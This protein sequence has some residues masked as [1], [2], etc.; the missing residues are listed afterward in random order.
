MRQ[1][2]STEIKK[3]IMTLRFKVFFIVGAILGFSFLVVNQT[4]SYIITRD[5]AEFEQQ[6]IQKN[7]LRVADAMQGRI[8]E[9]AVK[10]SDWAQ[11][12]DTYKYIGDR[13][14]A[15]I[16]SNLQNEALELLRINTV[17]LADLEGNILFGKQV[18]G[19]QEAIPP[20]VFLRHLTRDISEKHINTEEVHGEI[21]PLP[22]SAMIYVARPVT[23]SDGRAPSNGYIAF[24]YFFDQEIL[25]EISRITHLEIQSVFYDDQSMSGEFAGIWKELSPERPIFIQQPQD[26]Q[27]IVGNVFFGDAYGQPVF[28][29]RV[30][31][32]REIYRKG[33]ESIVLFSQIMIVAIILFSG[34][35]FF[36]LN[37]LV[38]QRLS[39]LSKQVEKIGKSGDCEGE[40][41]LSGSDEFS[42]LTRHINDMLRALRATEMNRRESEK[43]FRTVADSAPVMIWMSDI[44]QQCTY[45]NKVWLDFTGRTLEQELGQGWMEEV[46][47]DDAAM[48]RNAYLRAFA[49]QQSFS[50]EYRL[51]RHDGVYAWVFARSVPHFTPD[52]VFLGY[53]GS[54]VDITER[55][56][57]EERN[58]N[59]I[60]E[61]EKMNRVMVERE[62][63]MIELKA[64]IKKL[65]GHV[66]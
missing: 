6:E 45:V 47:P 46:H 30:L 32:D 20:D 1:S 31:S 7:T 63:K 59:R 24:G 53:V 19:G 14:E 11:W 44:D 35:L 4:L 51:K 34:L 61:M 9:L 38:L 13:N 42:I 52:G 60:E 8:D 37:R 62:L 64:Q 66:E 54:C 41:F 27:Q 57:V 48:S 33:Q 49:A 16:Q 26:D 25:S 2:R 22:G 50:I 58:K 5:F 21:V 65:Q 39:L 17:V 12:D 55:K 18:H 29:L 36:L 56:E 15:Y 40:I 23:S 10:L 43:R 3:N 28:F